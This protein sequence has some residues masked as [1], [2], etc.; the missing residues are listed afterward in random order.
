M[1]IV[2]IIV[3][4]DGVPEKNLA[5]FAQNSQIV[6][7]GRYAGNT[8]SAAAET[9]FYE[10]CR[11]ICGD[12]LDDAD[13]DTNLDEGCFEFENYAVYLVWATNV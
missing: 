1:E 5:I 6:D 4:K 8:L 3:T 9:A 2:N 12:T 11:R 13:F 10:E 7:R